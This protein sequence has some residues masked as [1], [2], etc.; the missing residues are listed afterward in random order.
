MLSHYKPA[1]CEFISMFLIVEAAERLTTP[2]GIP[3]LIPEIKV[4]S[5]WTNLKVKK[6]IARICLAD[7]LL[8]LSAS[9]RYLSKTD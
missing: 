3:L 4:S 9:L 5:W 2:D 6:H 8:I 1:G 7:T